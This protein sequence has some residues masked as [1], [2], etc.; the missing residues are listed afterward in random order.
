[1][2]QRLAP[3]LAKQLGL[4]EAELRKSDRLAKLVPLVQERI[5]LL[6]EAWD[7]VDWA[8]VD[9]DAIRYPDPTL[10]VSKGLDAAQTV[11]ILQAGAKLLRSIEPFDA[12]ALEAEFRAAAEAA[13]VKVGAYF[14]PFRVAIT[15]RTVSPPL[16][17]SMEVLG[18]TETVARV[19][20]A[21]LAL[22]SH[23]GEKV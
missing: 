6:T 19:E 20:N 5:K 2:Q 21:T 14:A 11:E 1:L 13:G 7:K 22:Q 18:R 15:G 4:D 8:F 9:A 3:F 16:F 23:V 10:L 17:E 12:A